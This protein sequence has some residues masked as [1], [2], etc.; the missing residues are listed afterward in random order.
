MPQGASGWNGDF[1]F[2]SVPGSLLGNGT[3]GRI[4]IFQ[5]TQNQWF[6]TPRTRAKSGDGPAVGETS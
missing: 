6:Q 2:V 1:P 3:V 4:E 5:W